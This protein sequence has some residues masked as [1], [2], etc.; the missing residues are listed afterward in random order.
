MVDVSVDQAAIKQVGSMLERIAAQSPKRL[1][2]ELRRAAIYVCQSLRSR[3]KKAPKKIRRGE[4]AAV[5]SDKHPKYI[6]ANNGQLM[7]RWALTRKLN[8]PKEYTR[9]YYVFTNARR[10]KNGKRVGRNRAAEKRELLKYHSNIPHAGLAKASWGWV[11]KDIYSKMG[12]EAVTWKRGKVQVRDPMKFVKGMFKALQGLGAEA[13]IVNRLDYIRKAL[14]PGAIPEAMTAA[15]KR[16]E[17]NI[18][19]HIERVA[20]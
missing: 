11:M 15:A 10:G 17:Y 1:T 2:S 16:L 13:R 4:Y 8:T 20:K 9:H 12:A 18:T 6:N 3:T 7:R 14:K 19:K 5:P